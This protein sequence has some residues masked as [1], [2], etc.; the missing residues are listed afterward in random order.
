MAVSTSLLALLVLIQILIDYT[1]S[2]PA[3]SRR[4][5]QIINPLRGKARTVE[6]LLGPLQAIKTLTR[7]NQ[8]L[9]VLLLDRLINEYNLS[10]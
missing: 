4:R 5:Q 6:L 3:P 1:K 10:R 8:E 2:L 7:L 9:F